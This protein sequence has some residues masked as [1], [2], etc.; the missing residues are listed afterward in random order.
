MRDAPASSFA[1]V[2]SAETG[3]AP[4][5]CLSHLRWDFVF[6]RP[7]H[8]MT[9]F[10]QRRPVVYFEE[11]VRGAR[12][13]GLE[14]RVCPAS[15][16]RVATPQVPDGIEGACLAA[17]QRQ[18]LDELI[19]D[20]GIAAPVLWF[21]T[22]MMLPVARHLEASAVVYDCMDELANFRFAPPELL[23]LEDELLDRADVVFTGGHSL[24]E[25]NR[26]RHPR[27]YA[28]PSSV[29]RDHFAQA[30]SPGTEP[31]DQTA[32]VEP[33]L[34]FFGVIDERLDLE[35]IAALAD[36]RPDW[37]IV[38][39]G[40][41]VKIS[42]DDLP[43]RPNIHWLGGRSYDAL[44]AY[45]RGWDVALMPFALNEATRFISPTK[46]PEFLSAGRPVV[47]TPVRDV[48]R[49][50]REVQGVVI[51]EAD[52]FV[53]ACETALSL[54]HQTEAW[55]PQ[56]DDLLAQMSWDQT[57]LRMNRLIEETMR[58]ARR[59]AVP[60]AEARP[61]PTT[62][63]ARR[64]HYDVLV[65]GAGFAGSVMAERLAR[66]D[67]KRVLVV[68]RRPHIGG[69]AY[70]HI[71]ADGLLVHAY[72]PHIFHTNSRDVF[73]YLS[74]FTRWRDYEH[75]VLAEVRGQQVPIPINRTTLSRLFGVTLQDD[76]A[77]AAFLAER[78]EPVNPVRTSEDVV[79]S[80]VG[81][82]LYALFFQ[83]YTRKQ[84][85]LDPSELDRSVT[86]RIPTRT[87]TDDRYFTDTFQ[88]M[89]ADGYT[90]MFEAMLDHP[91]IDV[92]TGVDFRQ[93]EREITY[94]RLVFT[95]PIDEFFDHC[96]GPLPYRSLT[97]RHETLDQAR[98]QSVGTI[99]YPDETVFY[100]RVT[101]FKHLTGQDHPRTSVVYEYPSATGDP[102]YPVPRPENQA[103]YKRYEALAL[104]RPDVTFVGRLA[105]Y[106][107]YNMDQV[108]GQALATHRRMSQAAGGATEQATAGFRPAL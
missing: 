26:E 57:F 71:D 27:V 101:E 72:G 107:Y 65:V 97:F 50:Y 44:P 13:I 5:I 7:Q 77:A 11:P 45:L 76:A 38:M 94:G 103:L 54:A 89:P 62:R 41:V 73:D 108:V 60:V 31:S 96:Y 59:P 23:G 36:A 14:V 70:D 82:E 55:L 86:A 95:G 39:V 21:Y 6:Q 10:A 25:A 90:A 100:T 22:P 15:G 37:S 63:P 30:R 92:E 4:L 83:G 98:F 18:L 34:G 106:R 74:R 16:V 61:F 40:P 80:A 1:T 20:Q 81:R 79:V 46:T 91:L 19:A 9:R 88:A 24:Y 69:N 28:F 52:G 43:R 104:T 33:R 42:H 99:N 67:G 85:G 47:S 58:P 49:Q 51:A 48:V 93:V 35:L 3:L 2:V 12:A 105:S 17:V 68:D 78:A 29:D 84:W 56:V 66:H 53:R 102:Y 8:L 64:D 87:N 75:R 32:V